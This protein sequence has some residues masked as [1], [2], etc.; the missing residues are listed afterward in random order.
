[1]AALAQGDR[2]GFEQS[3]LRSEALL[4]SVQDELGRL[5]SGRLDPLS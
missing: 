5:L 1:M 4:R 3:R 2:Q